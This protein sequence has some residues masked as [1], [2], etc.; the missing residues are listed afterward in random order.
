MFGAIL[1]EFL[2]EV[3]ECTEQKVQANNKLIH[4][5]IMAHHYQKIIKFMH[6]QDEIDELLDCGFYG[7]K[8]RRPPGVP[9]FGW[10]GYSETQKD[11]I[12]G[13]REHGDKSGQS[14]GGD[15]GDNS[16]SG[17]I[18]LNSSDSSPPIGGGEGAGRRKRCLDGLLKHVIGEIKRNI[19]AQERQGKGIESNYISEAETILLS[20]LQLEDDERQHIIDT[21]EAEL[22]Y[23]RAH[24]KWICEAASDLLPQDVQSDQ[25]VSWHGHDSWHWHQHADWHADE[26]QWQAQ[27]WRSRAGRT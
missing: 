20:G 23:W 3:E 21:M 19:N 15:H 24:G 1:S 17:G 13:P 7:P 10:A 8:G 25:Q 18:V 2:G 9:L 5:D 26:W 14:L 22:T 27:K 6:L 16:C 12:I 11:T 4:N